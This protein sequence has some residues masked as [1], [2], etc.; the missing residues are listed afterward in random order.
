MVRVTRPGDPVTVGLTRLGQARV[1]E[2]RPTGAQLQG[3]S[4]YPYHDEITPTR[5]QAFQPNPNP[6]P[7]PT[8]SFP[9]QPDLQLNAHYPDA[10]FRCNCFQCGFRRIRSTIINNPTFRQTRQRAWG[11][12]VHGQGC[13]NSGQERWDSSHEAIVSEGLPG[14]R[15][16]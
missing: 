15:T 13:G 10:A 14:K 4:F 2:E 8:Q 5:V 11:R 9:R 6:N 12:P 16:R 3:V 7:T 1:L